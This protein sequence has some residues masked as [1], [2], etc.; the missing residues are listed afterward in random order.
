M[1]LTL[2]QLLNRLRGEVHQVS[3][4]QVMADQQTGRNFYIVDVRERGEA[5]KGH[6]PDAI[7]IPRGFLEMSIEEKVSTDRLAE[8][9]VYCAGGNRS[10]LAA[11]DLALMGYDNVHSMMGGFKAWKESGGNVVQCDVLTAEQ[12][13]RYARHL[14]L[15]EV[16]RKSTRLNSSHSQQSRMPSSA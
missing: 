5:A 9:V 13:Q 15:S 12:T 14:T 8:I 6:I 10:L 3:A 4:Q 7:L 1:N 16:D 11:R 2:S